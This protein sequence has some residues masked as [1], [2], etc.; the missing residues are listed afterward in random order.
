MASLIDK[1]DPYLIRENERQRLTDCNFEKIAYVIGNG[2]SRKYF[3][4]NKLVD[5]G[6]TFGCNGIY[7]DFEVDYLLA[8][9][10][11]MITEIVNYRNNHATPTEKKS[12]LDK[13]FYARHLP[14]NIE[15]H[16]ILP[17]S[18]G[19][20]TGTSAALLSVETLLY[21]Q[22]YLLG[23]DFKGLGNGETREERFFNNIYA[24]SS[25][26]CATDT[27]ETFFMN[28]VNQID[29]LLREFPDVNIIRVQ[30]DNS[31]VPEMLERH[32]NLKHIN[33]QVFEDILHKS[34]K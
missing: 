8:V 16:N 1:G 32:S 18:R 11:A 21:T 2:L 10:T 30:D 22:V 9:D 5:R 7:R 27:T 23:F 28:W 33:Y 17:P 12:Y 4:L 24:D 26:Y 6:T 29:A 14:D 25:N 13:H 15:W 20:S 3:D 31:F 19:W 34:S